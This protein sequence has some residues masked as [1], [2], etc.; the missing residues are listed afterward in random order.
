MVQLT[1]AR[2]WRNE[3]REELTLPYQPT[4][5]PR[6]L[7]PVG[8][9]HTLP[10]P[11]CEPRVSYSYLARNGIYA[12]ARHWNLT[13]REVLFPAYFQGV[14]LEALLA[15]GARPRFYPVHERMHVDPRDVVAR[16]GP[17]TQAIYLIHYLGFPGPV[18][19]LAEICR[20]R[21]LLLIEDCALALLSALGERPLGTFGDAA[22]FCLYKT[23]P[24]PDGGALVDRHCASWH[25][26]EAASPS[27]LSTFA[28]AASSLDR[29]LQLN[30]NS[31]LRLLLRGMR[32]LG[33]SVSRAA[34][35]ERVEV[36][37]PHFDLSHANWAMSHLSHWVVRAQDFA[38]IVECRRRNF[39]H[40]LERLRD[41][42][43]P[44]FAELPPNVC[45]LLYALQVRNREAIVARLL[46]CGIETGNYWS[47]HHLALPAGNYEEVDEL[48]RTVLGLPCHQ[49]LTPGAIERLADQVRKVIREVS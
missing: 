23:L 24:V 13:G 18:K 46:E 20:N 29:N 16:I 32:A 35:V 19:E 30:G 1:G 39:L 28:L 22:I 33:K 48:R 42:A 5:A 2:L 44:V 8:R 14:E 17:D 26:A 31:Q 34:R 9:H 21:G 4:L 41:I 37:T 38:S 25:L 3:S 7:F 15:A 11:F 36:G 45:P 49:D 40:L 6:M 10:Y 12:L 27:L 43:P 47:Q